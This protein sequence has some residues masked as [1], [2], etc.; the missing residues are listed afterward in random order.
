MLGRID[1]DFGSCLGGS[2][3]LI[4]T[5]FKKSTSLYAV[6]EPVAV[7]ETQLDLNY[8]GRALAQILLTDCSFA[9]HSRFEGWT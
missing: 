5:H 6:I 2:H 8:Y 3:P 9:R 7:E 4:K 1:N